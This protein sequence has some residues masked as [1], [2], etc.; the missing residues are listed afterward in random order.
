VFAQGAITLLIIGLL[1]WAFFR[2]VYPLIVKKRKGG[3][4]EEIVSLRKR[5]NQKEEELEER[6]TMQGLIKSEVETTEDLIKKE[7]ELAKLK[8]HLAKL[9]RQHP[10]S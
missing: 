2:I 10:R 1:I 4:S 9:E 5:I 6:R 3:E 7:E 8:K